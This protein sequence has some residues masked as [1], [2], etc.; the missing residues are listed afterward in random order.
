MNLWIGPVRYI[1]LLNQALASN[2]II[3]A[4]VDIVILLSV[5]DLYSKD[6]YWN[7]ENK[8]YPKS[9]KYVSAL[10]N[11]TNFTIQPFFLSKI[12]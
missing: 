10:N 12:S 3:L 4:Y 1:T 6:Y 5:L 7:S 11:E 8:A 2:T 9:T